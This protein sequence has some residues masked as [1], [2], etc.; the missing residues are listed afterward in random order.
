LGEIH[1]AS[2]PGGSAALFGFF[3]IPPQTRHSV[4]EELLRTHCRAQLARLFGPQAA[5]PR[6]DI[7]KDWVQDPFTAIATDWNAPSHHAAAPAATPASGPWHG[8]LTGIASE[9]SPQFPGYL[10]DAIEAARLGVQAW[11]A[12]ITRTQEL[13]A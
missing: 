11:C 12:H 6:V 10:A 3:G 2:L 4:G 13:S 1:D 8:R 7:I 5:T 9:W